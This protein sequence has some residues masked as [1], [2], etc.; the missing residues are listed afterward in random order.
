VRA[1]GP[2]RR[3]ARV[4][5]PRHAGVARCLR[6]DAAFFRKAAPS[7]LG[8]NKVGSDANS[9]AELLVDV[10]LGLV[11]DGDCEMPMGD[12]LARPPPV[13]E[14][15]EVMVIAMAIDVSHHLECGGL[16][17]LVPRMSRDGSRAHRRSRLCPSRT[18]LRAG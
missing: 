15:R 3:N 2:V 11:I 14:A 12:F 13:G 5:N 10:D 4:K 6:F 9:G 1:T 17:L 8:A 7:R 18:R 16:E